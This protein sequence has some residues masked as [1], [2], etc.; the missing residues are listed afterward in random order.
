MTIINFTPFESFLGGS[1]IG[2]SLAMLFLLRGNFNGINLIYYDVISANKKNFLWSF[3]YILGLIFGPVI[4]SFFSFIDF[5]FDMPT[6][7]P[8]MIILGGL[9]V[10]YGTRFGS[11]C[12]F[13][14]GVCGIS[15]LSLSS[16]LAT[17]IFILAGISTV[18]IT[19]SFG[20]VNI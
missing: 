7:N 3:L 13:G 9:F 10:G 6:K 5:T 12:T 11:G 20:L 18:L 16:I 15:K 2:I 17:F 4:I 19:K 8:Y 14:H 1:F